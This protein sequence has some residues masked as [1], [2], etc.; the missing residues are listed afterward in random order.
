MLALLLAICAIAII[1][2]WI[3]FYL[4]M[5]VDRRRGRDGVVGARFG[6]VRPGRSVS[7]EGQRYIVK[8]RARYA[9]GDQD[10]SEAKLVSHEGKALWL[11]WQMGLWVTVWVAQRKEFARLGL[12]PEAL[13]RIAADRVGSFTRQGV[14]YDYA[15]SGPARLYNEGG[16]K[17]EGVRFWNFEDRDGARK[18][19]VIRWGKSEHEVAFGRYVDEDEVLVSNYHEAERTFNP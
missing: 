10:W 1:V 13:D 4:F 6:A 8:T 16:P 15:G 17:S 11:N 2:G 5:S 9:A 12:P 19:T 3:V 14:V 18:I 7:V